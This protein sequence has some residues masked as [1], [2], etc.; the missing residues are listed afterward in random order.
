MP[1]S[2]TGNELFDE[3]QRLRNFKQETE[4]QIQNLAKELYVQQTSA[5]QLK[6]TLT[7]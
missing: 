2:S 5:M 6:E 3:I 7:G 1:S 4:S